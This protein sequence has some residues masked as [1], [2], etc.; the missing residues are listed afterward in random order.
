MAHE[1]TVSRGTPSRLNVITARASQAASAGDVFGRAAPGEG[2]VN[3]FGD[4]RVGDN[5]L[6]PTR[7]R[8]RHLKPTRSARWWLEIDRKRSTGSRWVTSWRSGPPRRSSPG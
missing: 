1:P 2:D 5:V 3:G 8:V 7:T 4:L 6:S